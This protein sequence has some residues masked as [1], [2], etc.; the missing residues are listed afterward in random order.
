MATDSLA[1]VSGLKFR[2]RK[3]YRIRG[4]LVGLSG[5][6]DEIVMFAHWYE[7]GADLADRPQGIAGAALVLDASGLWRYESNCYPIP[8]LDDFAAAGSGAS[9]A[10]TAMRLGK[11][12]EEAVALACEVDLYTGPPVVVERL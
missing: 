8:I 7:R 6:M 12:P 4:A 1:N 11:T 2:T 9:V 3:L 5:T 10:L